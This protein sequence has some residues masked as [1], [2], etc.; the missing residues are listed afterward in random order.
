MSSESNL[1]KTVLPNIKIIKQIVRGKVNKCFECFDEQTQQ[2][3]FVKVNP[4]INGS[5]IQDLEYKNNLL[6]ASKGIDVPTIYSRSD[7][8]LSMEWL[9]FIETETNAD[10]DLVIDAMRRLH[11]NTDTMHG[12]T[13]GNLWSSDRFVSINGANDYCWV[14]GNNIFPSQRN[15]SWLIFFR[16]Q[17]WKPLIDKFLTTNDTL[18]TFDIWIKGKKIYDI[19]D[20]ILTT[21]PTP[22]LLHGDMNRLNYGVVNREGTRKVYLF[23]AQCFY[24]DPLYD[25]QSFI[26]WF[27][28]ET[29]ISIV[30]K[31]S[32]MIDIENETM[33]LYRAYIYLSCLDFFGNGRFKKQAMETMDKII[34]LHQQFYPSLIITDHI[35]KITTPCISP[36]GNCCQ[37]QKLIIV[38]CGSYN[39]V[40]Y[41]HVNNVLQSFNYIKTKTNNQYCYKCIMVP[42]NDDRIR[43]KCKNGIRLYHRYQMLRLALSQ[44]YIA[45][46][47]SQIRGEP[48]MI[49]YQNI[50]GPD[51]IIYVVIGSDALKYNYNIFPPSTQFIVTPRDHEN[52]CDNEEIINSPRV[53]FLPDHVEDKISSTMIRSFD[54]KTLTCSKKLD[55]M[56]SPEVRDY[57]GKLKNKMSSKLI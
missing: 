55:R 34:S 44:H 29:A 39:P 12:S 48:T 47:L 26:Q 51:V 8:V 7:S 38:Q 33:L 20:Q 52:K 31:Y 5:L 2:K 14:N 40:H 56:I 37:K 11:S 16:E 19:M 35:T 22:S 41:N 18:K 17:R 3:V 45:L 24:G 46:D 27:D 6:L 15:E 30:K 28:L 10:I 32:Q 53:T 4:Y 57:Y 43:S 9:D 49:N 21:N 13:G 54:L 1:L 25:L 50:Y 23:D 36:T 42:S